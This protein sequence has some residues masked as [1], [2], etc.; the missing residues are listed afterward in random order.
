MPMQRI[1]VFRQARQVEVDRE[2]AARKAARQEAEIKRVAAAAARGNGVG[3]GIR[4]THSPGGL[5]NELYRQAPLF[6]PT[7]QHRRGQ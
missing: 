3:G 7:I 6:P 1:V 2:Q 4:G 5:Y